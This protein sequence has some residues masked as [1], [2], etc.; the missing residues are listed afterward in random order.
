MKASMG[1][2][3][4]QVSHYSGGFIRLCVEHGKGLL[5]LP[6]CSYGPVIVAVSVPVAH[7]KSHRI[8]SAGRSERVLIPPRRNIAS[9]VRHLA[10]FDHAAMPVA[11]A[12][13]KLDYDELRR[14]TWR[15][16]AGRVPPRARCSAASDSVGCSSTTSGPSTFD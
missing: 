2:R 1:G 16:G 8:V 12:V 10:G 6:D 5:P 14:W 7:D 13:W 4:L 9:H 15:A 3:I 11:T